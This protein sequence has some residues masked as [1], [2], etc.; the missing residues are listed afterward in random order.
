VSETYSTHI[1]G[2][3]KVAGEEICKQ[4]SAPAAFGSRLYGY[5]RLFEILL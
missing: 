4:L 3:P 2:F 1:I 5:K